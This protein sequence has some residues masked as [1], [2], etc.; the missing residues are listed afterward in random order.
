MAGLLAVC[1]G[2][3]A[4]ALGIAALC[5]AI[6]FL[7]DLPVPK[8]VD[9]PAVAGLL[10]SLGVDAAL[11]GLFAVQHSV[12]A[13]PSFKRWWTRVVPQPIERST[14]V[15]MSAL[16]LG[17]L[18]WQWRPIEGVVWA[19]EQPVARAALLGVGAFGWVMAFASTYLIDHFEL[20]G[21]R[22]VFSRL[23]AKAS[24]AGPFRTPF[25]Y[26]LVRH[27]LY[28]GLLLAFWS[29]PSMS[30]GHALFAAGCTAYI[31]LGIQLEER[32]L[33]GAFGE[34]YCRYQERVP[35]LIP[36]LFPGARHPE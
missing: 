33:V 28:L 11:L 23:R 16:V 13:R 9:G 14:Y 35:M 6:P 22:Q 30:V 36:A 25:L 3:I 29:T 34:P 15:L 21:L 8:T 7:A 17:L 10:P 12:M 24:E 31:L 19:V 27:P 26:R 4:Y 5:Y 32:D 1:Y 18:Y 20:F 2:L